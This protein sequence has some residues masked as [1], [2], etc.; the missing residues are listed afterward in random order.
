MKKIANYFLNVNKLSSFANQKF[1][2][3]VRINIIIMIVEGTVE[4][5]LM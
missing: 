1:V 3:I 5:V 2:Y 4:N